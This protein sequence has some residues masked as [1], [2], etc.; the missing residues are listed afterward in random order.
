MKACKAH[1]FCYLPYWPRYVQANKRSVDLT[2]EA[3]YVLGICMIHDSTHS[4]LNVS[5]N[6][7]IK[8]PFYSHFI[9]IFDKKWDKMKQNN[10]S[11]K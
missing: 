4:F 1:C 5:G 11:L 10:K 6:N 2:T 8:V 3:P 9:C 7:Y